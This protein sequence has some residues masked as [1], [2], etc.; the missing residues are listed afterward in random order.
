MVHN[1]Y[2]LSWAEQRK[3]VELARQGRRH[4]DARIAR[5][6]DAWAREKTGQGGSLAQLVVGVLLG[7]GA[8]IG[9]AFRERRAARRIMRVSPRR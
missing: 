3:V 6:A 1:W 5:V 8:S 9:E 7:D 2:E 4:P